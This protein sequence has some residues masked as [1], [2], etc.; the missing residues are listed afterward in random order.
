MPHT[1]NMVYHLIRF[2][3]FAD[4][5]KFQQNT[6]SFLSQ[7]FKFHPFSTSK[8]IFGLL[9]FSGL[10]TGLS[11]FDLSRFSPPAEGQIQDY[12]WVL[13][14]PC[15]NLNL[16]ICSWRLSLT[17]LPLTKP[18]EPKSRKQPMRVEMNDTVIDAIVN[19]M[20][21][22][23]PRAV[24]VELWNK[25]SHPRT[26]SKHVNTHFMQ[27]RYSPLRRCLNSI[28]HGSIDHYRLPIVRG[29]H[30]IMPYILHRTG[31]NQHRH[32]YALPPNCM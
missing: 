17:N 7:K 22:P 2:I 8:T 23:Q 30:P 31:N 21:L 5:Y 6:L 13:R 9:F 15:T 14:V 1:L 29:N 20:Q 26:V 28:C 19:R 10:R 16:P 32:L 11:I 24:Y 12:V 27:Q 18:F 4:L 25:P 3:D